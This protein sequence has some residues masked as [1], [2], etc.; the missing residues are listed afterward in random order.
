MLAGFAAWAVVSAGRGVMDVGAGALQALWLLP[1]LVA[2]HLTQLLISA[3]AW[4]C[5]VPGAAGFLRLFH[6]LRVVREGIDSLLPV[7]QVGGELIGAQ[8]LARHGWTLAAAGASVVVD[9]TVEFLTQLAFLLL[10]VAALAWGS[11][12]AWQGWA[13]ALLLTASGAAGL[14]AA[15]RFGLLRGLEALARQIAAR[16][17][18]DGSLDGIDAAVAATYRRRAPM[19]WCAALHLGSWLLGMIESWAV[20]HALGF[21]VSPV[22]ALVVEALGMAARSAGFAVPGAL[23]VQEAG[24]ALAAGAA[25]LPDASGVSLSL[26]KR[27]REVIVGLIGLALWQMERRGSRAAHG[28]QRQPGEQREVVDH[29][30]RLQPQPVTDQGDD[31][32]GGHDR[33][34]AHRRPQPGR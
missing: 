12:G 10:G 29:A 14:L 1:A 30:L 13:A 17:A 20:L 32:H 25:G 2:L 23:V 5:L 18:L 22:Q 15:Q 27:A 4:Q 24:F 19:L 7:A 26:V 8:L 11:P 28:W 16:L 21:P 3:R 9:V 33:P 6:R 31:D 34:G